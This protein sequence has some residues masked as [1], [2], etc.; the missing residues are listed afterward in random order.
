[1]WFCTS[2][3]NCRWVKERSGVRCVAVF[4]R[5]RQRNVKIV[6]GSEVYFSCNPYRPTVSLISPTIH[7]CDPVYADNM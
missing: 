5:L 6:V 2:F 1:M 3:L 4:A 7:L